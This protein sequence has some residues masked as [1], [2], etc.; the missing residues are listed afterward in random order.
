MVLGQL[1]SAFPPPPES[2]RVVATAAF[3]LA[4]LALRNALKRTNRA[5]INIDGA[6]TTGKDR[7]SDGGTIVLLLP[8]F[9]P[10]GLS[11]AFP[12]SLYLPSNR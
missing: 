3:C 7:S 9:S 8:L 1:P 12:P 10:T 11:R 5:I 2:M 6:S 4:I